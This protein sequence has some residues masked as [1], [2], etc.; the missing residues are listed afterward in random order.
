MQIEKAKNGFNLKN[1]E[2]F[3]VPRRTG[4]QKNQF[5]L[6][7]NRFPQP[8]IMC[9]TMGRQILIRGKLAKEYP[10]TNKKNKQ[11][12]R[13]LP[14]QWYHQLEL[15]S[16]CQQLKRFEHSSFQLVISKTSWGYSRKQILY[17]RVE[18]VHCKGFSAVGLVRFSGMMWLKHFLW[19]SNWDVVPFN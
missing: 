3:E 15:Q 12:K 14:N 6:W 17:L 4:I 10:P 8:E 11:V 16:K 2:R 9:H 7:R 5:T 18:W 13:S 1:S 19:F